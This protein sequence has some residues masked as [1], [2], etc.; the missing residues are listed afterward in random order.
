MYAYDMDKNVNDQRA[1]HKIRNVSS[2]NV[3]NAS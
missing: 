1:E 2:K 3:I